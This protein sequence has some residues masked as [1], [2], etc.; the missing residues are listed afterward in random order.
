MHFAQ[1]RHEHGRLATAS[2]TDDEV[3]ATPLENQ[4]FVDVKTE[5]AAGRGQSAVGLV[6]GPGEHGLAE[7]DVI[8]V[9]QGRV[10]DDF[11][12]RR[13]GEFVEQLGLESGFICDHPED[14]AGI[15]LTLRRKSAMRCNDTFAR[16]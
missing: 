5:D 6:A 13:F 9:F 1:E 2:W 3:E 11:L 8:L 16:C 12:Y 7:A 10:Y 4:V 15:E 14:Y